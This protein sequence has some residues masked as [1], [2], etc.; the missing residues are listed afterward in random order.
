MQNILTRKI[1]IKSV[2]EKISAIMDTVQRRYRFGKT[3][4]LYLVSAGFV[5]IIY[6]TLHFYRLKINFT[7]ESFTQLNTANNSMNS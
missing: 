7:T 4:Y 6:S 1:N 2:K 5:S 3:F